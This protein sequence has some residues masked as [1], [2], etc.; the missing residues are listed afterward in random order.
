MVELMIKK[1]QHYV[2]RNYLKAWT[3]SKK[4]ISCLR[5]NKIYPSNL[6]NVAQEKYFYELQNLTEEEQKIIYHLGIEKSN[7]MLQR[8]HLS[9]LEKYL[10]IFKVEKEVNRKGEAEED[11]NRIIEEHKINFEE[12]YH[13]EIESIGNK[14]IDSIRN[15]NINFYYD[16]KS[17]DR[18]M[19]LFF[20][21]LQ[22]MR[23][24]RRKNESI[25]AANTDKINMNKLWPILAH[26]YATNLSHNLH[27]DKSFNLILLTN[28]SNLNFITSDQP[29]INTYAMNSKELDDNELEFYYPVSPKLAILIT[30][31][32]LDHKELIIRDAE[33][34]KEYNKMINT[35]KEE[36][37]F[38]ELET[39]LE[40]Y[41][42]V[43]MNLFEQEVEDEKLH[44]NY[45]SLMKNTPKKD[46]DILNQWVKGFIDR[47]NKLVKEFQTTF[48]SSFWEIYLYRLFKDLGFNFDWDYNRPDFVLNAN[49]I[50]FI[51]EATISNNAQGEKEEWQ[52]EELK[53]RYD[54]YLTTMNEK[55]MY[56][57]IRLSNSFNKKYQKYKSSY[58]KLDHV[59]NK[60]FVLAIAPFEQPLHYHQYDR[61]IMALLYDF[62]V[63]E[64]EY[65]K[66]PKEYPNG[67]PDERLYYVE[68]PNGSEIQL[69][70]FMDERASEI[71]AVLFNPLA[72]FAKAQNM[73]KDKMGLFS[74]MWINEK[75]EQFMTTDEQE[76]IE[77]GLFIFH[78]PFAKI[79]LDKNIFMN[80]RICQV[81]MD[82]DDLKIEKKIGDKHLFFRLTMG[83]NIVDKVDKKVDE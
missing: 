9:F 18:M 66:N 72:T 17:D 75:N 76:S 34:I 77:D 2:S 40:P 64:E 36:Q 79:P 81:F 31:D 24:K 6:M 33:K 78:N 46:R 47:D 73:V 25:R 26:I 82:K 43:Q 67:P 69:G 50:D 70:L 7:N 58:H 41:K 53:K 5:K 23:T 16:K 13:S 29:I 37:L 4:Q 63:N 15:K 74:H 19:F 49:G 65:V 11:L 71:S 39:D 48:N 52:K 3:N 1:R 28:K 12:D 21:T 8:I 35:E 51:I 61:P 10:L 27:L 80:D 20:L 68:K 45:I 54:N 14:Y 60:P 55:N 56:S 44:P 59:K 38:A 62:Y 83:I 57:I 32:I 42:E 30:K 22:Y